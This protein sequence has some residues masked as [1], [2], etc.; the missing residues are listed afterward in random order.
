MWLDLQVGKELGVLE[1]G[2]RAFRRLIAFGT[3]ISDW[4]GGGERADREPRR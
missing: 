4:G 1:A 3:G 2:S